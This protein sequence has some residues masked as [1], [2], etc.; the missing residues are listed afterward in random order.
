[1]RISDKKGLK[2][3]ILEGI[4]IFVAV[5]MGFIA[6]NIREKNSEN[7][8]A[9]SYAVAMVKDLE[10]DTADL[11]GYINYMSYA[12]QN[13]DTLLQLMSK[14][15][16]NEIPSGQLYWFGL[17]G[18]AWREYVPN[19]ATFQQMKSS[20]ALRFITNPVLLQGVVNF[21]QLHRRMRKAEENDNN[22]YLEVRKSR[23]RI[24]EF[25]YNMAANKIY[26]SNRSSLN[27]QRIDSFILTNPPM[28]TRDKETFNQYLE[29]VRSRRI[30]YKVGYAKMMKEHASVLI[31]KF[32]NEYSLEE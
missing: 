20:G 7:N 16:P 1:M 10:A 9:R 17:W 27:Q 21:D 24:F 28:L 23:A 29:L 6:D 12:E 19:D 11:S 18:G 5:S 25:K 32:R 26:R 13:I 8:Q 4:M 3:Y 2:E 14:Y 31:D 15:E 30:G 22:L